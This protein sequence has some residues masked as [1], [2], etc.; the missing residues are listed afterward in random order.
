VLKVL[1]I[2]SNHPIEIKPIAVPAFAGDQ[3]AIDRPGP[4]SFS[5]QLYQGFAHQIYEHTAAAGYKFLP[6]SHQT[7]RSLWPAKK[8]S[9][10]VF[11]TPQDGN[12]ELAEPFMVRNRTRHGP[13][14]CI[15]ERGA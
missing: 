9:S 8:L 13:R 4:I 7:V 5:I 11:I 14:Y 6:I 3:L 2:D 10:T 1:G 15:L 12:N